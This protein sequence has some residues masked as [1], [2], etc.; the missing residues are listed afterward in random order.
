MKKVMRLFMVS[1]KLS[2][3]GILT[4]REPRVKTHSFLGNWKLCLC[5]CVHGT[6]FEVSPV[7]VPIPVIKPLLYHFYRQE[8]YIFTSYPSWFD[9][10]QPFLKGQIQ[11][12]IL[13]S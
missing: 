5:A 6:Y 4:G 7:T 11:F 12:F 8:I 9:A 10:R 3:A 13:H 2:I 1:L